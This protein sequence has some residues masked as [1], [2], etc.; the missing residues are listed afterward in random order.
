M[1]YRHSFHAGNIADVFKHFLLV[2]IL[3]T[4]KQKPTPFCVIDSHA[5]SGAYTLKPPGEYEQGIGA[6]WAERANWPSLAD[7]FAVVEEFNGEGVLRRYP[8]SP[9]I[10][11]R[12]LRAQ[13]RAVL[14][15]L[16]PEEVQRLRMNAKKNAAVHHMD[17]WQALKAFVPPKENRG[18]VL[19]DPPYEERSEFART[20]AALTQLLKRWRNGIYMLWYPIKARA[21]ISAWYDRIAALNAN[22]EAIEFLTLPLDVPQRLNGSG[23]LLINPPWKL[24]DELRASLPPLAK[25]LAGPQGAPKVAFYNLRESPVRE[26]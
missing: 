11:T 8:G 19:I 20:L 18:L 24:V 3:Q 10:I 1:N 13:D 5:G 22:A 4:L 21:P 23:V 2:R 25:R 17:G 6:L 9:W 26:H 15:E 7:Y 12:A 16:H 14:V